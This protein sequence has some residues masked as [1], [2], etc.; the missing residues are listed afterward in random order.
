MAT[1]SAC[2]R[3]T[4]TASAMGKH[5]EV[6]KDMMRDNSHLKTSKSR[7]VDCRAAGQL[8]V[9]KDDSVPYLADS[10][11]HPLG[12]RLMGEFRLCD[13]RRDSCMRGGRYCYGIV[14]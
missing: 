13:R 12:L 11:L 4:Q 8:C 9:D 7:L 2:N 1:S 5:P 3:P 14:D 6:F 10:L